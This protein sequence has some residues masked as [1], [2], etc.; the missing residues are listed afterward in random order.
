[1]K[2]P[3][4]RTA[5]MFALVT[6][7]LAVVGIMHHGIV[8]AETTLVT[9]GTGAV[10]GVYYPTGGAISRLINAKQE[11]HHI[12]ASVESTGGS[13]FNVDAIMAGELEFGIVQSDRQYQAWKGLAEWEGKPQKDLRAIFS[14]HQE[15]ITL[16]ASE[17]SGI[18]SLQDLKNKRVNIGNP[19]SGQRQNAIDVLAAAG[20]DP[21]TDIIAKEFK[22]AEAPRVLQAGGLDA[23]F[24]T[25]GHPSRAIQE[26]TS[27]AI[28]VRFIPVTGAGIDALLEKYAYYDK[29]VITKQ[30]YPQALNEDNVPTFGVKATFV[31]SSKV[32]EEIVSTI[33]Q[34]VFENLE[35]FKQL[36]P[37]YATLT[38]A[39][40]L[41]ALSADLH[42]GAQAYYRKVGL[43]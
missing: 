27:G 6:V 43:K 7:S 38:K 26:A 15:S 18:Q 20:L 12:L 2:R 32:S 10:T 41:E 22:A 8:A 25:V 4:R 36:H 37:A 21:E 5:L 35:Q 13:V 42:P 29:A 28:K 14:I 9:I 3:N 1:M 30:F 16:V 17:T 40:M 11:E 33:V 19:G 24:Y 23:F 34:A 31:T 39:N